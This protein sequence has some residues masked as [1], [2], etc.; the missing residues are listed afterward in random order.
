MEVFVRHDDEGWNENA[1]RYGSRKLDWKDTI[2]RFWRNKET[3]VVVE[4]S[5][6]LR[7]HDEDGTM[8]RRV[9]YF[10]SE[11]VYK[12]AEGKEQRQTFSDDYTSFS[13]THEPIKDRVRPNQN[14]KGKT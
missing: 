2:P 12:D 14:P 13:K 8:R 10:D 1:K 7:V 4:I 3:G 5:Q 6:Y 9:V 11:L